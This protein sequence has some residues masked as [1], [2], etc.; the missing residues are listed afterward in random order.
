MFDQEA[1]PPTLRCYMGRP[2]VGRDELLQA[3]LSQA[4]L[5]SFLEDKEGLSAQLLFPV[6]RVWCMGFGWS[7]FV[8]Q[9]AMLGICAHAG[10]SDEYLLAPDR[11]AP[12]SS[13][14]MPS[15][16]TDDI[17]VFSNAEAGCVTGWTARIDASLESHGLLKKCR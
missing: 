12:T 15:V 16:A 1:L 3:G 6:S 11:P 5:A 14:V 2:A 17:M 7:S 10:L 13:D 9:T 8:T 4:E